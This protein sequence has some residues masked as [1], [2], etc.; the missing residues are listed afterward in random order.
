MARIRS[1]KP[2]FPHSESMGAVSRD[3]RLLFV[4]LWTLV[5]DSGRAR[6]NSRI[7]ASL[8]FP[9]DDDAKDLIGGWLEELESVSCVR[10]YMADGETYIE[11]C[12][13]LKHQKIDRPTASKLPAFDES[14]ARIREPSRGIVQEVDL[15]VDLGSGPRIKETT[16]SK[17]TSK[18][19]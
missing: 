14:F 17:A 5:D 15:E 1:I 11:V 19:E 4:Q 3:A 2:E 16:N 13:W 8:L 18:E 6:G 10:R 12:K 7:L 9:Y